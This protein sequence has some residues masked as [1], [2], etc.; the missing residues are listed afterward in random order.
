[1]KQIKPIKQQYTAHLPQYTPFIQN[2]NLTLFV[3]L[4][5]LDFE[6]VKITGI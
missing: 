6:I 1:M 3:Y 5:R 4:F 2:N